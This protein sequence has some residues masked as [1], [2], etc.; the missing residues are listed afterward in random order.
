MDDV[1][2][3]VGDFKYVDIRTGR[4]Y[5]EVNYVGTD[6]YFIVKLNH[7]RN[8]YNVIDIDGEVVFRN[9][10]DYISYVGND[11]FY[12]GKYVRGKLLKICANKSGTFLTIKRTNLSDFYQSYDFV[13]CIEDD[14]YF[15]MKG[16]KYGLSVSERVILD[17]EYD[18]LGDFFN[19]YF[20]CK[21]EGRLYLANLT[22]GIVIE[23]PNNTYDAKYYSEKC[24]VLSQI[25]NNNSHYSSIIDLTG[26]VI[27]P[28]SNIVIREFDNGF[29]LFYK[30]DMNTRTG[31]ISETGNIILDSRCSNIEFYDDSIIAD[32]QRYSY[33]GKMVMRYEGQL[34]ELNSRYDACGDF[35]DGMARVRKR[36]KPYSVHV[37]RNTYRIRDRRK[38]ISDEFGNLDKKYLATET[39]YE[40]LNRRWGFV[41]LKGEEIIPC[42]F[43]AVGNF[44][45]GLAM[46]CFTADY[47][48]YIDVNGTFVIPRKYGCC[49]QFSDGRAFVGTGGVCMIDGEFMNYS[50]IID[51]VGNE[52]CNF[53]RI[54][55]NYGVYPSRVFDYSEGLARFRYQPKELFATKKYGFIDKSGEV[56]IDNLRYAEDFNNGY[57]NITVGED[58]YPMNKEGDVF[59]SNDKYSIR[60]PHSII[61]NFEKIVFVNSCVLAN[62]GSLWDMQGYKDIVS[63]NGEIISVSPYGIY[64]TVEISEDGTCIMV[65][66]FNS[67]DL[68]RLSFNGYFLIDCFGELKEMRKK[69]FWYRRVDNEVQFYVVDSLH[70]TKGVVDVYG[71]EVIQCVYENIEVDIDLQLIKCKSPENYSRPFSQD[72][73]FEGVIYNAYYD[74]SF[75]QIIP[76]IVNGNVLLKNRYDAT[77]NFSA[78]DLAAVCND[79]RWGFVDRNGELVIP[80]VYL[81]VDDYKDGYCK[82]E[83]YS[84]GWITINTDGKRL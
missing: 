27:F 48:G 16:E 82:V 38:P 65:K 83:S 4:E 67:V 71:N 52:V 5:V 22:D 12:V 80:C 60:I 49:S 19:S 34:I 8:S 54:A 42:Q 9:N 21:K 81:Q 39:E 17:C 84:D 25:V 29:A 53:S 26:Q 77:R 50:S 79:G 75:N 11:L 74:F 15:L 40:K 43:R 14:C 33:C 73:F 3:K 41:N 23:L 70:N 10:Y 46:A 1:I 20:I 55:D 59:I 47:K 68:L 13:Y 78:N 51:R 66:T 7:N 30:D 36:V 44:S 56:A 28:I 24:I 63:P 6:D 45:D 35:Y 32:G 31:V 76:D 72:F 37:R 2:V 69:Y 61:S 58:V 18:Y 62:Y 64:E 57:A